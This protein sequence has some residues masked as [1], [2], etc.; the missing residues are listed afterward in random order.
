MS[1][2]GKIVKKIKNYLYNKDLFNNYDINTNNI[3]RL[4]VNLGV[5]KYKYIRGYATSLALIAQALRRK[6][7][8]FCPYSNLKA[9]TASVEKLLSTD[10]QII[11]DVFGK[12]LYDQY[13]CGE[14]NSLAFECPHHKGLHHSFEH[15][16]IEVLD[17][18]G[19]E[20]DSGR[21]II[22]NLD[23]L[24]FPLIRYENGDLINLSSQECPCGRKS[25]LIS[26]IEGRT[27]DYIE[28]INGSVVHGGFFDDL[29]LESNA[30]VEQIQ[31]VQDTAI[32][33]CVRYVGVTDMSVE[34]MAFIESKIKG[35][36]GSEMQIHFR[37]VEF[38]N[39]ED[40]GKRK[41]VKKTL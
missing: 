38:V 23:N 27:F 14:V 16:Y 5:N 39:V 37:K 17:L 4:I 9:I 11:E 3:D 22:T 6:D 10:R 28:G 1:T 21:L 34:A 13:G 24:V 18:K 25:M 2:R 31:F 15:S 41:L 29:L 35:Q 7:R 8:Q 36:L 33:I 26:S 30:N 12:I 40:N 20:S 32:R 19:R